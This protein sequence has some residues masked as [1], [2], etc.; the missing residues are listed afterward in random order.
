MQNLTTV[1]DSRSSVRRK[2][3]PW[4]R[5]LVWYAL[6]APNVILFAIFGLLPIVATVLISF[7]R[8]NIL[9]SPSWLGLQ[10][11]QRLSHDAEFWTSLRV[12]LVYAILFVIPSAG[13]ALG[14]AL[15]ISLAG[16]WQAL[17]RTI[18]FI[19]VVTSITVIAMI[20]G[21][22]FL[23]DDT[24]PLNYL[25]GKIGI[26]PQSWLQSLTQALPAVAMV[27]V[28]SAVGYYMVLWLSGLQGI[29]QELLDAAMVDGANTW[30]RF[31]S[32]TLPLLKPTTMFIVIIGTINAFQA[33]ALF[34]LLT[35]GGPLYN[36]TTIVLFI[37]KHA[38]RLQ[39]MGY[40][41]AASMVLVFVTIITALI[42]RRTIG[43]WSDELYS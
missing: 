30:T 25:I 1:V 17:F 21:W 24:G 39:E 41:S 2:P 4:R 35:G 9:G 19:P 11:F 28:W 14:Q 27:A 13:I 33:F 12:T 40:A 22:L 8:W 29:P 32:I 37:Y 42:Q 23:P 18:Y 38:F 20:W 26:P 43:G 16:R 6:I 31:W 7:T 36:T 15:L 10:N 3:A 5:H 34:Y